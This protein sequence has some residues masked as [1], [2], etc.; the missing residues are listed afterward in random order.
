MS[1]DAVLS[2]CLQRECNV[3]KKTIANDLNK[4]SNP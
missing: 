4:L 1:V 3:S 2:E